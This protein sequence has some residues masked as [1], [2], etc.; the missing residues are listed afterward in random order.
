M[1]ASALGRVRPTRR[2]ASRLAV[3]LLVL[4]GSQMAV[5]SLA[6]ANH[7]AGATYS[8]T[9]AQGGTVSFT[10]SPDGSGISSFSVGGP[11]QGDTCSFSGINTNYAQPLPV[12]NHAFSDTTP[13]FTASGS[14]PGLQSASGTF[15][16]RTQVFPAPACD[17]GEVGWSA[18][19]TSSPPAPQSSAP[20]QQQLAPRDTT[21]PAATLSGKTL[22]RAGSSIAVEVSCPNE[23]CTATAS[24]TVSVPGGASKVYRL[25]GAS[26]N[27]PK[28]GKATLKLKLPRKARRAIKRALRSKKKI[29][30]K[31][32]VTTSDHAGNRTTLKRTIRLKR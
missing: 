9:H 15:R 17:S 8:G 21:G 20:L 22:Q 31:V 13:P 30:A 2:S 4:A 16:M 23:P 7:I 11:V 26:A 14:F 28:G 18:T 5:V 29:K 6:R 25:G 3:V 19:T 27:V 32:T 10:V 12:V 24:G 1:L